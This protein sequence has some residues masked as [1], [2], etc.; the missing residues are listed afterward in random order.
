MQCLI[1]KVSISNKLLEWITGIQGNKREKKQ[2][3]L[4]IKS[5][6]IQVFTDDPNLLVVYILMIEISL[7][8]FK[9]NHR[10]IKHM[11]I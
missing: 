2:R 8:I 9:L 6:D 7:K 10:H 5:H 11:A 3:Y 1:C 4:P